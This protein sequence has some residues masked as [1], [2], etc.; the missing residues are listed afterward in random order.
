MVQFIFQSTVQ[1]DGIYTRKKLYYE[2]LI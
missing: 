2:V 1:P